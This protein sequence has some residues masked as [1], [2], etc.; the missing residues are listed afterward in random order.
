MTVIK[1]SHMTIGTAIPAVKLPL[2]SLWNETF[3]QGALLYVGER[4]SV[5]LNK[6]GGILKAHE[7]TCTLQSCFICCLNMFV[8]CCNVQ[9]YCCALAP[10][11]PSPPLPENNT[12][13]DA[14]CTEYSNTN[15]NILPHES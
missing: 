3:R 1:Q 2:H 12:A 6:K 7:V 11:P 8:S 9:R 15:K 13:I 5:L 4:A 10:V 14:T